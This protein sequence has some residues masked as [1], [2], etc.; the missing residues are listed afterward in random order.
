MEEEKRRALGLQRRERE[1]RQRLVSLLLARRPDRA[2]AGDLLRPVLLDVLRGVARAQAGGGVGRP[3]TGSG[4]AETGTDQVKTGGGDFETGSDQPETGSDKVK[5]GSGVV[6]P[7]AEPAET[8]SDVIDT[9]SSAVVEKEP[10]TPAQVL[11]C[12]PNNAP[13]KTTPTP[14]SGSGDARPRSERDKCNREPRPQRKTREVG[15]TDDEEGEEP[16]RIA[17]R[18]RERRREKDREHGRDRKRARRHREDRG[19]SRSRSPRHRPAWN[20]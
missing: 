1:L 15:G 6:K 4:D 11:A 16:Q 19:R 20:R 12:I 18:E 2:R 17:S 10:G 7:G 9:G 14:P 3:E 13:P 8:G 5:T